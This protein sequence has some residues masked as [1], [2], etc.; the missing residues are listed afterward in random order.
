LRIAE[1]P[2]S[3]REKRSNSEGKCW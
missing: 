2:E 3:I 1:Y